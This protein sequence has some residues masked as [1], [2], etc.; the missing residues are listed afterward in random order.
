ME[1]VSG[2]GRT[3]SFARDETVLRGGEPVP[4]TMFLIAGE[5]CE[6]G[7]E[8][9]ARREWEAGAVLYPHAQFQGAPAEGALSAATELRVFLLAP[10]GRRRLEGESPA[11]ALEL[12]RYILSKTSSKGL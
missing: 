7:A 9:T 2:Y 10:E 1:R 6:T 4:G 3:L 12:D 8:K 11:L 5:S